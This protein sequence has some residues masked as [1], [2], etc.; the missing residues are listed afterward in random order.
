M[1]LQ[2]TME[3]IKKGLKEGIIPYDTSWYFL[4][5]TWALF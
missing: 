3:A 4:F 2:N 1:G 5:N